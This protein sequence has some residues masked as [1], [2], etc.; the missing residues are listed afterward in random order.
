MSM[1]GS[2]RSRRS[3]LKS[4]SLLGVLGV[5]IGCGRSTEAIDGELSEAARK[6]VLQ[7]RIDVK[8]RSPTR[9]GARN[10]RKGASQRPSS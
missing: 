2:M 5:C 10:S 3:L 6:A 9:A 1:D 4:G 7:K 8:N